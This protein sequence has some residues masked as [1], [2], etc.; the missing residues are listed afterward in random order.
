MECRGNN[1]EPSQ[2]FRNL[3]I[4]DCTL[5]LVILCEY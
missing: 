4:H 1:T 3:K 2:I 5:N